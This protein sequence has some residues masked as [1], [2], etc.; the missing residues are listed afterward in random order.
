MSGQ[1]VARNIHHTEPPFAQHSPAR[2][3]LIADLLNVLLAA[4]SSAGGPRPNPRNSR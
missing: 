3:R 4:V 1:V 2:T